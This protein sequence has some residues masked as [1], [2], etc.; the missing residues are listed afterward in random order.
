MKILDEALTFDDVLLLPGY[1]EVLPSQV[2]IE[3]QL[4]KKIKLHIP[5][6]S[7]A[8]DTVTESKTAIT[9]AQDGGL[10]VIHKN[11]SIRDQAFEVEKVKKSEWGMILDPITIEP[12][13]QIAKAHELMRTYKISGVPVTV[14][15]SAGLKL[16]GILTNRDLRFEDDLTQKVEARMTKAPLITVPEGTTLEQAKQILKENR[17]EKLPVVDSKGYLKGLITIKDIKKRQAFPS[18]N[19]DSYGRLVVGAAVGVG[20]ESF[21]RS[22]AL[23]E[24]GVDVLF[25]DSAHGHSKGVLDT[26]RELKKRFGAKVEIVGGNIATYEGAKALIQA[27]ADGVKVGIGPGSICTTRI[28][29]GIGVPQLFAVS[30]AARAG[31]EFGVPI[32]ADGGVKYSGDITKALAAGAQTVMVGSLFAGTD[33]APGE[34]V[35]YQGRSYKTYRGMGSLGAMSQATGSK[36]RYFQSE[37]DEVGKLVPEGIE[38]RVPYRGSLSF[39]VHQLLGGLRAGMGYCGA[40]SIPKLQEIAK[41]VRITNSGLAESHPHDIDVT[42]EAPNYRLDSR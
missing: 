2:R 26:V 3:T 24:A 16:V 37:V 30:E 40:D 5:M 13:A 9:L 31:R 32:V 6:L 18:A 15:E 22:Q 28:I 19:K 7:A 39:N 36:D 17:I 42:K 21:E 34:V 41:F 29:A 4:T 11:L 35:L 33:E 38:G 14:K 12:H 10:G 8:M 20:A 1:S 23:V 25:V 27:G